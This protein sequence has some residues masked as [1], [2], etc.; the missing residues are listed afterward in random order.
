MDRRTGGIIGVV[1][2]TVLCA[3]P[4][5]AGICLAS[6]AIMG[7][8]LPDS[9]VPADEVGIVIGC[10]MA[11]IGFSLLFIATPVLV[12]FLVLRK[13]PSI[14]DDLGADF[15]IPEDDF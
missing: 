6:M 3:L 11:I 14:N 15:V 2:T 7:G 4:G 1:T 9:G 8:V 10:S 5:L 13:A 12:W